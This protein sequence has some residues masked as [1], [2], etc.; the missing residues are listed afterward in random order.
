[1]HLFSTPGPVGGRASQKHLVLFLALNLGQNTASSH[2]NHASCCPW[3]TKA[4]DSSQSLIA[5]VGP[6]KLRAFY[7]ALRFFTHGKSCRARPALL[8]SSPLAGQ[9]L[10]DPLASTPPDPRALHTHCQIPF[11]RLPPSLASPS[12]ALD[13]SFNSSKE[14]FLKQIFSFQSSAH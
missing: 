10:P 2:L 9:K 6:Q 11:N 14:E 1:M 13:H 8:L 12:Y 7:H 4:L 3:A 5:L